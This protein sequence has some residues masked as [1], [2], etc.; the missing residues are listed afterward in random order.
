MRSLKAFR[1]MAQANTI[2]TSMVHPRKT[3][4]FFADTFY[5]IALA[6]LKDAAHGAVMKLVCRCATRVPTKATYSLTD[7]HLDARR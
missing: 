5:W 1:P 6:N 3:H 4:E 7:L 2:I